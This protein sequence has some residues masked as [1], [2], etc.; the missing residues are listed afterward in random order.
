[1]RPEPEIRLVSAV[2]PVIERLRSI[3][4]EP[5]VLIGRTE[6]GEL[7][8]TTP[9]GV[10][11]TRL[12]IACL[13]AAERLDREREAQRLREASPDN[14]GRRLMDWIARQPAGQLLYARARR[15]ARDAG[16]PAAMAHWDDSQCRWVLHELQ[17]PGRG[18]SPWGGNRKDGDRSGA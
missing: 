18:S 4:A 3:T 7:E 8:V 10:S 12:L 17:K 13:R 2:G 14:P 9:G 5:L 15:I 11:P 6:A 16:L 1:M